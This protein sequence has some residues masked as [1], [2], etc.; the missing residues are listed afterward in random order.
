MIEIDFE[1]ENE[2]LII[3]AGLSQTTV[4]DLLTKYKAEKENR[5]LDIYANLWWLGSDSLVQP[6]SIEVV[7]S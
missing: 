1:C 3:V 6:I 2:G 4:E 7:R 5:D